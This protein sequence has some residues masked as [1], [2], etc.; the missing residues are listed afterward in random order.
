MLDPPVL[1]EAEGSNH[2]VFSLQYCPIINSVKYK[3]EGILRLT[4]ETIRRVLTPVVFLTFLLQHP[5]VWPAFCRG[6][7]GSP[8][9]TIRNLTE[10]VFQILRKPVSKTNRKGHDRLKKVWYVMLPHVDS[11]E[12]AMQSLPAEYLPT[13]T[14]FQKEEFTDIFSRLLVQVYSR[15]LDRYIKISYPRLIIDEG[16]IEGGDALV[17]SRLIT[18]K[19]EHVIT[20][21]LHQEREKW[22]IYD[23]SYDAVSQL[24]SY[25]AQLDRMGKKSAYD[26]QEVRRRI[27]K[28]LKP[29][30]RNLP[31]PQVKMR[32][33]GVCQ[34]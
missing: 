32:L 8:C 4:A 27:Q 17:I 13:M 31:I 1:S 9:K 30:L 6:V 10:G 29:V 22:L 15:K 11:C 34:R 18:S 23:I 24:E 19:K 21:R 26:Y 20:F 12:M 16:Q 28:R 2:N 5:P 14:N 33:W 25:R 7:E 3:D